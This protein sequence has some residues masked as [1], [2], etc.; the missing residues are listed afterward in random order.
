MKVFF[1]EPLAAS[2]AF[3]VQCMSSSSYSRID[4]ETYPKPV[5][6]NSESQCFRAR[7]IGLDFSPT[8]HSTNVERMLCWFEQGCDLV[9]SAE[10]KSKAC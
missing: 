6:K 9:E 1:P 5:D 4:Q 3:M 2:A 10:K 8:F 7:V